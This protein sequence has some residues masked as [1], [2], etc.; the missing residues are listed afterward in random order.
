[1]SHTKEIWKPDESGMY[2]LAC[3]DGKECYVAVEIR[4]WGRLSKLGGE[5]AERIQKDRA[6]RIAALWNAAEELDLT[7]AKI[8]E[9]E[10]QRTF[11]LV[12][13]H[14][15]KE[16]DEEATAEYFTGNSNADRLLKQHTRREYKRTKHPR[17]AREEK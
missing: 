2:I 3:A 16:N 4:G 13:S 5:V 7:T 8:A 11:R 6:R 1:M 14:N 12:E 9:G 10:I 17:K 15:R